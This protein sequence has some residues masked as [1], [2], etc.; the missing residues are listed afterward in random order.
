MSEPHRYA[1]C[2]TGNVN[3]E[4]VM[5]ALI[6]IVLAFAALPVIA[7]D[8]EDGKQ[9]L[10]SKEYSRATASF[11]KAADLG[12]AD[13]QNELGHLYLRGTGVVQDYKQ[14]I[15]WFQRSAAQGHPAGQ[16]SLGSMYTDGKGVAKD[17]KQAMYWFKK[18]AARGYT[19]AYLFIG[20]LYE[21]AK[22]FKRAAYW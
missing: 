6:G 14:A 22:D 21:E 2:D 8:L 9:F 20:E 3:W 1:N 7:G 15:E 4:Q 13:A 12:S 18:A 11:R 10:K 17:S 16:T 19:A 5:K